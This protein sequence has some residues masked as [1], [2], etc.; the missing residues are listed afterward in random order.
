MD[1]IDPNSSELIDTYRQTLIYYP[2]RLCSCLREN[3][4]VPRPDHICNQG[5]FYG[6]PE[7]I[8]GKRRSVSQKYLIGPN[9]RLFDGGATFSIPKY[10]P[11]GIEQKAY[12]TLAHGDIIV[13]PNKTRRDTDILRRSIRDY[14]YAFD[15]VKIISIYAGN[16]QFLQGMD[17]TFSEAITETGNITTI[18]WA[19]NK[20]PAEEEYY[21]VEFISK[22]QYKVWEDDG[23]D[24]GTDYEELPKRIV[25]VIRRYIDPEK[26]TLDKINIE[27]SNDDFY[28]F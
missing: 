10:S 7:T 24:R 25:S 14:I 1:V 17:F 9:G 15:I 28:S 16:I 19:D 6:T 21:A 4:G 26:S 12:S 8:V 13:V 22:Q 27:K 2:G 18:N 11:E 20:G 3:S 5:F 23:N